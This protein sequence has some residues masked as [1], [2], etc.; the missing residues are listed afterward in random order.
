MERMKETLR[1]R[2]VRARHAVLSFLYIVQRFIIRKLHRASF[3]VYTWTWKW[4]ASHNE[5]EINLLLPFMADSLNDR[6]D[7]LPIDRY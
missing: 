6:Y 7:R 1:N 4:L 5:P 2:Y 3:R